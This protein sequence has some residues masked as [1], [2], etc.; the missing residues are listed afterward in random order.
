MLLATFSSLKSFAHNLVK[1]VSQ[2]YCIDY[3]KNKVAGKVKKCNDRP[4][5]FT[6]NFST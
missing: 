6:K 3:T 4:Y 1:L 5:P 2:K